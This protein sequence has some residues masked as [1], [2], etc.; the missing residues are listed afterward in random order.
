MA[1]DGHPIKHG[2]RVYGNKTDWWIPVM[3]RT[4][5]GKLADEATWQVAPQRLRQGA[6]R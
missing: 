6:P 4:D 2:V 1:R 5:E 3:R